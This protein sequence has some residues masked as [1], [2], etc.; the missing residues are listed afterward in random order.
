MEENKKQKETYPD[1]IAFKDFTS[2]VSL[3]EFNALMRLAKK[4]YEDV[5]GT[6]QLR[7]EFM[8]RSLGK[9]KEAEESA[10]NER[11]ARVAKRLVARMM[12]KADK[13]MIQHVGKNT[14]SD[15]PHIA[16]FINRFSTT[17]NMVEEI[18]LS[19]LK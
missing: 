6:V 5:E 13:S 9:I 11:D 10:L 8:E 15:V 2:A 7:H 19:F 12:I 4:F 14:L 17:E 16:E 1:E 18:D 3:D